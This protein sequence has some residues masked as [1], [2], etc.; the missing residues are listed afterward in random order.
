M[1]NNLHNPNLGLAITSAAERYANTTMPGRATGAAR[2]I[3]NKLLMPDEPKS[4]S[5]RMPALD[6]AKNAAGNAKKWP[7]D[8]V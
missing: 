3:V 8:W 7:E 2:D 4:V 5:C 1:V 6:N